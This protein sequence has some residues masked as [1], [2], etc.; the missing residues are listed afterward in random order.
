M[1]KILHSI[2]LS[3]CVCWLSVT[4]VHCQSSPV[5]ESVFGD[6][7][8]V[9]YIFSES[10]DHL[11]AGTNVRQVLDGDTQIIDGTYYMVLRNAS[12]QSSN[13]LPLYF[14]E[15]QYIRES[16]NH[17]KLYFKENFPGRSFPEILVMDLNLSIGDTLD[18]RGWEELMDFDL[19]AAVP[20]IRVDSVFWID[21]RKVLRTDFYHN[22]WMGK[23]TLCFIE[24][25]GP[26]FGLLYPMHRINKLSCLFKDDRVI[27][28]WKNYSE[29]GCNYGW[30]SEI[31]E[32]E[33]PSPFIIYPNPTH[34]DL[35]IQFPTATEYHLTLR[36]QSGALLYEKKV[37][38]NHT[39][40]NI[41]DYPN[42]V[43][44]VTFFYGHNATTL[45]VIK[46]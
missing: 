24:G 36:T 9:W 21:H 42:G 46:L 23:D 19:D 39:T 38:D 10:T 18:T 15:P 11:Y 30:L 1:K 5:Y 7:C 12:Y 22:S 45:K 33:K 34:N 6:S 8:S 35:Y 25:I 37:D 4:T 26:T 16:D 17:S 29:V 20:K 44:F 40:L 43:Y 27:Y 13:I 32:Q 14:D 28:H 2:F 3:V 41:A 31:N